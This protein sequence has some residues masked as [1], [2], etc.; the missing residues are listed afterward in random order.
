L[1]VLV[2]KYRI[3]SKKFLKAESQG[4]VG[5]KVCESYRFTKEKLLK[6]ALQVKAIKIK[7]GG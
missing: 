4:T 7:L 6:N 2:K 3:R 5:K 1:A